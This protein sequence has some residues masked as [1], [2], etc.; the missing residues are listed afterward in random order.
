MSSEPGKPGNGTLNARQAITLEQAVRGFTQGGAECLGFDRLDKL[1][2]IEQG[3][4]ADFIV[5]DRN[6]P[7]IPIETVKDTQVNITVM[8]GEVR[9]D[10]LEES[11]NAL[12]GHY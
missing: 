10:Q 11:E 3:K 7:E 2:S 12:R 4:L 8:G 6:F 9:F 5:L 1:G